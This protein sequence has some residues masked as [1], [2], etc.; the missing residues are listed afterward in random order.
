MTA[1]FQAMMPAPA[2]AATMHVVHEAIGD[3][4][5]ELARRIPALAE[6]PAG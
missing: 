4:W 1:I 2:F 6:I 3:G 5:S